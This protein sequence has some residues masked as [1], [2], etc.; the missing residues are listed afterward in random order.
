MNDTFMI[1]VTKLRQNA[2][3]VITQV[4]T[5]GTNAIVMQRSQ[6]KV[7]IADY[8]YFM[9]LQED[10]MNLIDA[11]DAEIAKEEPTIK[12]EDYAQKRWR[13]KLPKVQLGN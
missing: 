5:T 13:S 8:A 9:A 10:L 1:P 2:A 12:I 4:L 11:Q 3:D 6:P 7:V